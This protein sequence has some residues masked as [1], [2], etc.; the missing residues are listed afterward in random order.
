M[1]DGSDIEVELPSQGEVDADS[2]A[3][4]DKEPDEEEG[5]E[6]DGG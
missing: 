6:T 3:V 4:D 2:L 5:C 1:P